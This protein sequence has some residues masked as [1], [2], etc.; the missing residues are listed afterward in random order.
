MGDLLN[1]KELW[2]GHTPSLSL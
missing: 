1:I 2:T